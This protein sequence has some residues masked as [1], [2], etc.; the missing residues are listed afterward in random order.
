M[1]VTRK[2]PRSFKLSCINILLN[3]KVCSFLFY[4]L[5]ILLES[6]PSLTSTIRLQSPKLDI[7]A[8]QNILET[9]LL[10][11]TLPTSP[12]QVP[13]P[14][15]C[16]VCLERPVMNANCSASCQH[17]QNTCGPCVHRWYRIK[18]SNAEWRNLECISCTTPLSQED[19]ERVTSPSTLRE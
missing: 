6:H 17:S 9:G 3:I 8:S 14:V 4:S 13:P 16:E 1:C 2:R 7:M 5:L 18:I 11:D 12:V 10:P 19:V 15:I